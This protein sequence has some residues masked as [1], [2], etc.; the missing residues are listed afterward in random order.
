ML[1]PVLDSG[2]QLNFLPEALY[3]S[4]F[5]I[6]LGFEPQEGLLVLSYAGADRK[7]Q[8]SAV[9]VVVSFVL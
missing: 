5:E 4:L 6:V 2:I 3:V 8:V 7:L 9:F 1:E